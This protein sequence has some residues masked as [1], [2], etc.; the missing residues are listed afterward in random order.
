[1][2]PRHDDAAVR[3]LYIRLSKRP[4]R[5]VPTFEGGSASAAAPLH[6]SRHRTSLEER[7]PAGPPGITTSGW[8]AFPFTLSSPIRVSHNAGCRRGAHETLRGS[9]LNDSNPHKR[10]TFSS[11]AP[12]SRSAPNG[13]ERG[14]RLLSEVGGRVKSERHPF[15][16]NRVWTTRNRK[17]HKSGRGLGEDGIG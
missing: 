6:V 4:V 1:M 15:L 7:D 3:A 12:C 14:S 17:S 10:A 5:H 9:R 8:T 2:V 16:R 11:S 13:V